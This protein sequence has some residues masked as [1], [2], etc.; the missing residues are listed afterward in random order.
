MGLLRSAK[1]RHAMW[2]SGR[3]GTEVGRG[4]KNTNAKTRSRG[5]VHAN[6]TSP[7]RRVSQATRKWVARCFSDA[8]RA[9]HHTCVPEL[10]CAPQA[11]SNTC[12]LVGLDG[13]GL[14]ICAAGNYLRK[15]FY[16]FFC[17]LILMCVRMCVGLISGCVM[18][19]RV[20]LAQ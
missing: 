9:R 3:H 17:A 4:L 19:G 16:V 7:H 12:W 8:L 18:A 6:A 13:D 2:A 14:P 15:I 1:D 11:A 10:A 20:L 5:T